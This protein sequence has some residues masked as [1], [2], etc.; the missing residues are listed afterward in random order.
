VTVNTL[1]CLLFMVLGIGV[2]RRY[3]A[4]PGVFCLACVL[5]PA[6][7]TV[8]SMTRFVSVIV[9]AF[10]ILASYLNRWRLGHA[11]VGASAVIACI[12]ALCYSHWLF[13]A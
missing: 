7:S 5:I 11:F 13:V 8:I 2:W 6:M 9:P 1:T 3:G 10:F 4:G 12:F